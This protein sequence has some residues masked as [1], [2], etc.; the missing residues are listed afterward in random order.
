MALK[1]NL[2][3]RQFISGSALALT[4]L[5]LNRLDLPASMVAAAQS[6]TIIKRKLG[7]TDIEIPIVSMGV[8]NADNP[9]VVQESYK[10]GVRFF[11]TAAGYQ[12]GRNEE[13]IGKVIKDLGV[14]NQVYIQTKFNVGM[15]PPDQRKQ[16][17]LK[18]LD[19]SLARLGMDYVDTFLLHQ[20]TNAV[21]TDPAVKEALQE[22]KNLKKARYVGVSHHAGQAEVL[23]TVVKEGIY[24]TATI[25]FNFSMA[26]DTALLDAIKNAAKAGLGII[27]MK[28]QNAT[29]GKGPGG[30]TVNQTAALKWVLRNPEITSAIP[31]YTNFDMMKE[32]FSVASGL[33][34]N[35]TEKQFLSGQNLQALFPFCRQCETCR[36]ICPKGV[37]IPTL[38][39][40]HMYAA[41]YGNFVQA[42]ATL[43]E[44]ASNVGLKNCSDCSGCNAKC[45]NYVN[46]AENIRDLK[47]M[48]L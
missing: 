3:R 23:N 26:Q 13:M 46:I 5:A 19:N 8:M 41:Q 17:L 39:R 6:A 7:K 28:T 31:G 34:Y 40:T 48:Y 24:D 12:N 45:A 47:S 32:D 25:S 27:A 22:M 43:D 1:E 29:R 20:P 38:M 9:A 11:D 15:A 10:L 35:D 36:S 2:S 44:I 37:D 42:R 30:P 16:T 18:E 21:M 33:D 4:P 14:R